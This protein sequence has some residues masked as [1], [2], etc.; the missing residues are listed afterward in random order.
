MHL[1]LLAVAATSL[2]LFLSGCEND[3]SIPKYE[4]RWCAYG[5]ASCVLKQN[6]GTY[7]KGGFFFSLDQCNDAVRHLTFY[8]NKVGSACVEISDLDRGKLKSEK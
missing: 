2:G 8:G 1:H 7:V 3:R 4:L 6:E 5:Q